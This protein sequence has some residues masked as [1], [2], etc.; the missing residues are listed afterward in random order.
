MCDAEEVLEDPRVCGLFCC[1]GCKDLAFLR[2]GGVGAEQ[3]GVCNATSLLDG[4]ADDARGEAGEVSAGLGDDVEGEVREVSVG[5]REDVGGEVG[6]AFAC[7]G[8]DNASVG[9]G[10][11][12][13]GF[14]D[15]DTSGEAGGAFADLADDARGE[16]GGVFTDLADD[17]GAEAGEGIETVCRH[18]VVSIVGR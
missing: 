12:F 1:R 9:P 15:E 14:G 11:I 5:L 8:D 17:S 7:V 4:L 13:A 18:G 2:L 3:D 10:E 6:E 16:A